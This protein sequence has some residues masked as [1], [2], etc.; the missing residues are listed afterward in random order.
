VKKSKVQKAI[1]NPRGVLK[2]IVHDGRR[3]IDV[4]MGKAVYKNTAGFEFNVKGGLTKLKTKLSRMKMDQ[5]NPFVLDLSSKGYAQFGYP[6]DKSLIERLRARFNELINDKEFSFTRSHYRGKVYSRQIFNIHR[7]IPEVGNLLNDEIVSIFKEY[8]QGPFKVVNFYGFRNQ[9][10]PSE[11]AE[12]NELFSSAWHCDQTNTSRMKI[13]VYLTEVNEKDGPFYAQSK[14]RT[15]QLIKMGFKSRN[16]PNV[17]NEALE[18]PK[19][20]MKFIG[21]VGCT[22]ACNT[23]I[24][25]HRATIPEEG[26]FRDLI[27]IHLEPT[28]EPM[29]KD[30]IK[31]LE[32]D[33]NIFSL[34]QN[35]IVSGSIT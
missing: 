8:F 12:K 5:K 16:N 24:C 27:Q 30:W 2:K 23:G 21:N 6:Y 22:L 4:P 11:I 29:P 26:H 18:D 3:K 20:S 13:F 1:Q 35:N 17:P 10:V 32:D 14:K 19:Y 7:N 25:L 28:N 15:Q 33:S 31:K 34:K 9:H